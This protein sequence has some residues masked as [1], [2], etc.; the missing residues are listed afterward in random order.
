MK[1]GFN[2]GLE[3]RALFI[4]GPEEKAGS[5]RDWQRKQDS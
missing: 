1:A 5:S 3:M 4:T 2:T